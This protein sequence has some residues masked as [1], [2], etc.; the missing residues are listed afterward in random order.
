MPENQTMS[1]GKDLRRQTAQ[2]QPW[3]TGEELKQ[4][5]AQQQPPLT[6]EELK[7]RTAQHGAEEDDAEEE[8]HSRAADLDR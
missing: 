5:T 8:S 4:C 6:G 7:R 1:K 2:Q 3:P